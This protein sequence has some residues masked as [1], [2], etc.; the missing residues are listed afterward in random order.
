MFCCLLMQTTLND[1]W[2]C[3]PRTFGTHDAQDNVNMPQSL[4]L[5]KPLCKTSLQCLEKLQ[6]AVCFKNNYSCLRFHSR[7]CSCKSLLHRLGRWWPRKLSSIPVSLLLG[8]PL[9]CRQPVQP[10]LCPRLA[11]EVLQ[12][13]G[14]LL[15]LLH[16]LE[17]LHICA[18]VQSS[19]LTEPGQAISPTGLMVPFVMASTASSHL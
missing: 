9:C 11:E 5:R 8:L 18:L 17:L 14:R 4:S 3:Q 6:Q 19:H 2:W 7:L 12:G 1:A 15:L 10:G 13:L 16:C